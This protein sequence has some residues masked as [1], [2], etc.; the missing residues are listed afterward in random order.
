ML[1]LGAAARMRAMP[2]RC[3]TLLLR[4]VRDSNHSECIFRTARVEIWLEQRALSARLAKTFAGKAL[5]DSGRSVALFLGNNSA[6]LRNPTRN[7]RG[8]PLTQANDESVR[9]ANRRGAN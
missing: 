5:H 3:L 9:A 1:W 2:P 4:R 6:R 7:V 8:M